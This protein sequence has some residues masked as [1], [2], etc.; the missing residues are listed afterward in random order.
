MFCI[1][2]LA[3]VLVCLTTATAAL[4]TLSTYKVEVDGILAQ[5]RVTAASVSVVKETGVLFQSGF[6]ELS[7][8]VPTTESTYFR[9]ASVSKVFTVLGVLKLV[10]AGKIDLDQPLKKYLTWFR[11]DHGTDWQKITIRQLMT[12]S[13]GISR[14]IACP[15]TTEQGEWLPL[16]DLP[17]CVFERET[18]FVPGSRLKYSNLGI[19]LLGRVIAE[20]SGSLGPTMEEKFQNY[21][22]DEVFKPLGMT[23][24][25]YSLGTQGLTRLATPLGHLDATGFSREVLPKAFSTYI[26]APAWGVASTAEDLGKFL[27]FVFQVIDGKANVLLSEKL[28]QEVLKSPIQ[29]ILADPNLY[30]GLGFSLKKSNGTVLV[31]HGGH[32]PGYTTQLFVDHNTRTGY[33]VL[34]NSIERSAAGDILNASLKEYSTNPQ[35]GPD[36]LASP[37][38][39]VSDGSEVVPDM[40]VVYSQASCLGNL[41]EFVGTY[42]GWP[43]LIEVTVESGKLLANI[44]GAKSILIPNCPNPL[45]FS[46]NKSGKPSYVPGFGEKLIFERSPSGKMQTL[47]SSGVYPYQKIK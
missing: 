28:T 15:F 19:I 9:I 23:D 5:K 6:G 40:N 46:L 31:G 43:A 37:T 47:W 14:E 39:L 3:T 8:G 36:L 30:Q 35:P 33:V 26:S 18:M 38:T 27:Q 41:Q 10:E 34:T 42:K 11:L 17:S 4:A 32:F 7:P 29:D 21:M 13:S 16:A 2:R 24:T 22:R 12:H 25:L 45:E 20:V 1:T 44:G